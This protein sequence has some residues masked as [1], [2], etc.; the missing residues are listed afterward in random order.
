ME[1]E[2]TERISKCP[3]LGDLC[4]ENHKDCQVCI[5]KEDAWQR[6]E[7]YI[8]CHNYDW[9]FEKIKHDYQKYYINGSYC[10]YTLMDII[11]HHKQECELL[12]GGENDEENK[13]D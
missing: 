13:T 8:D 7:C 11:E 9:T 6:I 5:A 4:N 12:F 2:Y 1:N 3:I 10:S